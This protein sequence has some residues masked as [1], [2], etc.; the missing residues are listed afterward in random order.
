MVMPLVVLVY[1]KNLWL[2]SFAVFTPFIYGKN[3]ENSESVKVRHEECI[4]G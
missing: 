4:M 1:L 3:V 2:L